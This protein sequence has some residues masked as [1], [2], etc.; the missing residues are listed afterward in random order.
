[1]SY[2]LTEDWG[3]FIDI[4]EQQFPKKKRQYL[5]TTHVID[6]I[7]NEDIITVDS[8]ENI[9]DTYNAFKKEKLLDSYFK[10]VFYSTITVTLGIYVYFNLF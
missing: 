8:E 2:K 9:Y 4:E 10:S 1:M 7:N 6:I 5:Y 3:W